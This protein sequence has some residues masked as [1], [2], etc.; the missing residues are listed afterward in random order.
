MAA[1]VF[2]PPHPVAVFRLLKQAERDYMASGNAAGIDITTIPNQLA[3]AA[4]PVA[5]TV[6]VD[7]SIPMPATVSVQ[8]K[9]G[10]ATKA[11]QSPA[12]NPTT[13]AYTTT[14]PASTLVAGSA[15]AV[16]T[17]TQPAHTTTSNAFTVT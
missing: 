3:T 11:T 13:G 5:G 4:T 12:V 17:I 14:F 16:A 1:P 8:L 9:E 7:R 10:A 6:Y 15:T 2:A